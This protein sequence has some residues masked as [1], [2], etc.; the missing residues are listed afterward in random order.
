MQYNYL[1][2]YGFNVSAKVCEIV[3]GASHVD[4]L[5]YLFYT[6]L[7]KTDSPDPPAE[8]TRDRMMIERMVRLWT[9]FAK[10]G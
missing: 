10:T 8:G 6:P 7:Y 5:S 3:L 1:S 9:N 4:E 2:Q